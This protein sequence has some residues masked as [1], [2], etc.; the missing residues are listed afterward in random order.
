MNKIAL[1][2]TIMLLLPFLL[3]FTS[4]AR[5]TSLWERH[6]AACHDGKTVLNMKVVISKEQ[7]K[8]KYETIADLVK[9]VTCEGP[10]CMNILK[11]DKALIIKVGKEIGIKKDKPKMLE[12]MEDMFKRKKAKT[13][14]EIEES[15]RTLEKRKQCT[16]AAEDSLSL[17]RCK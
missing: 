8:A 12:V 13:V 6:C 2:L 14:E 1:Y 7:I 5:G 9:S 11:H 4:K 3:G 10:P 16:E 17:E 15:M